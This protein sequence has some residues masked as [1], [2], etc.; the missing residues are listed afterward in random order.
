MD[1]V[2]ARMVV[3]RVGINGGRRAWEAIAVVMGMKEK[4]NKS[5]RHH[6]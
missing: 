5:C 4:L 3:N 1:V 6:C 2:E